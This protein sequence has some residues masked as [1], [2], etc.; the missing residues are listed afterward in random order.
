MLLVTLSE[1]D[2]KSRE[3][4]KR[5]TRVDGQNEVDLVANIVANSWLSRREKHP[6][7]PGP[8]RSFLSNLGVLP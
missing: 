8:K 1:E 2:E 5:D 4:V 3:T 6:V 7:V